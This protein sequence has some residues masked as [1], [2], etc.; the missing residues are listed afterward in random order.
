M[1]AMQKK[2]N[3]IFCVLVDVVFTKVMQYTSS[4]YILDKMKNIYEE[5]KKFEKDKLQTF[6]AQIETLKIK[7]VE[8]IEAYFL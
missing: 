6:S 5:D 4:N 8:D 7:E 2:L 3:G 1:N